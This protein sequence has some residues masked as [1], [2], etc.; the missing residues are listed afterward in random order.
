MKH[1]LL[2]CLIL[3]VLIPSSPILLNSQ[4]WETLPNLPKELAFPVVTVLDGKIHV[5]GG[6]DAK[7]GAAT[8]QHFCYD[9]ATNKW[10]TLDFL[11]FQ[12]QQ[13]AGAAN[14]GKIHFS[15]VDILRPVNRSILIMS[16]M[17]N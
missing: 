15:A 14:D 1:K 16:M 5:F 9:P 8:N 4:T 11:P 10:K 7:A 12:A 6:G 2:F 17:W 13:P 3:V